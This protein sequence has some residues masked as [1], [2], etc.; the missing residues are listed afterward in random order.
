M[1]FSF[2]YMFVSTIKLLF[3]LIFNHKRLLHLVTDPLSSK[4]HYY[5]QK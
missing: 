3:Y 2:F 1:T 5:I 4:A